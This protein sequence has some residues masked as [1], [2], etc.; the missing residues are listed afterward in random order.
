MRTRI[1]TALLL[2]VVS[3]L[4]LGTPQ[5]DAASA[6]QFRTFYYDTPGADTSANSRLNGEYFVLK[7][8]ST[9]TRNLVGW[10]VKDAAGFTYRFSSSFSLKPG[11]SVTIH[12]G[13]GTNTA[14]HRYWGRT[15]YVW[16]N[17]GDKA[18][19]RSKAGTLM[20]SCTWTS[21]GV[22]YKTC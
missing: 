20:D 7:N 18:F 22:G 3:T 17:T 10:Y 15:W 5:A 4:A 21:R 16:N 14:T 6:I 2:A 11:A 9:T 19:L 13:K 8:T 12:T 1:V